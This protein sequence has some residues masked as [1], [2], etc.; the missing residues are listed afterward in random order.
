MVQPWG[1]GH[2][3]VYFDVRVPAS[4]YS[5]S[6]LFTAAAAATKYTL[7]IPVVLFTL[8]SLHGKKEKR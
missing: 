5:F 3:M 6:P 1:F 7:D 4:L 8:D 2:G